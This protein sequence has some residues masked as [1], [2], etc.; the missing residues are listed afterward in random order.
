[1]KPV[2]II[3]IAVVCSVVAVLGVLIGLQQISNYQAQVAYDE[4]QKEQERPLTGERYAKNRET[5]VKLFSGSVTWTGETLY[6]YCLRT[7]YMSALEDA[8]NTCIKDYA[9][10]IDYESA[11][12]TCNQIYSEK[13]AETL[14]GN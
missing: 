9:S 13:L 4:L 8:L 5:C 7:D 1:M 6:S 12:F 3:A 10:I 14:E 2:I 11:K